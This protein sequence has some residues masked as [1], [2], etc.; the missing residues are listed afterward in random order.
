MPAQL[1]DSLR[2][3]VGYLGRLLGETMSEAHGREFL[4]QIEHVR[5]LSKSARAGVEQ[6]RQR[7][8]DT[9]LGLGREEL[10]PVARAFSQFLNLANI[11][12]QHF[13]NAREMDHLTSATNTLADVFRELRDDGRSTATIVD[14]VAALS[15]ELVLTA[16]PTEITRRT[17]IHKYSEIDT[18]LAQRELEGLTEREQESIDKRLRELIAQIW[19]TH[20]FRH[21]RPT[22]VDEA[23]W[24]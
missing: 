12:D 24:G 1:Y 11:A 13:T 18:C 21:T 14:A 23:K 8:Q 7:L 3:N 6:D 5:L 16:H 15:I 10:L 2:A 4:E 9:L 22:P 17:L 20:D 19:H